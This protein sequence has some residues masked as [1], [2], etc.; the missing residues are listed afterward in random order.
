MIT[1]NKCEET[2]PEDDFYKQPRNKSG[3]MG[4]CKICELARKAAN[5]ALH[6]EADP[7]AWS[8]R[9]QAYAKKYKKRHPDRAA[10]Y[11]HKRNLRR[12][13]GITPEKYAELLQAQDGKCAGCSREPANRRFAVDHD[14]GCCPGQKTCGNCIRGLL[15]GNCNTGLGLFKENIQTIE[16][17]LE[18]LRKN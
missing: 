17:I 16:N 18:Y 9:Q 15:C 11:D 14:H 12:K 3:R 5:N 4:H 6:K 7:R 2:K 8:L 10:A 1:C 13:Y